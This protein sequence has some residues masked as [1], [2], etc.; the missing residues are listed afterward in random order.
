MTEENL[1][2]EFHKFMPNQSAACS[3]KLDQFFKQWFDT[4]YTGSSD[5]ARRPRIA[6][7][8]SMDARA[9]A[10]RRAGTPWRATATTSPRSTRSP[11]S[12]IVAVCIAAIRSH[13][14]AQAAQALWLLAARG[15]SC[16]LPRR[17]KNAPNE[18][19]STATTEIA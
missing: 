18:P 5:A 19:A 17:W 3:A 2:K 9:S 4:P 8:C 7:L 16:S 11:V 6:A 13:R 1:E 14:R 10:E 15:G 12:S